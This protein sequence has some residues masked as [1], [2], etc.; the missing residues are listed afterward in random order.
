[1]II[2]VLLIGLENTIYELQ[3]ILQSGKR[4]EFPDTFSKEFVSFINEW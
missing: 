1:M 2:R 3:Q 4:I